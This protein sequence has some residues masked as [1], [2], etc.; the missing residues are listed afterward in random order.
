MQEITNDLFD[1]ANRLRQIDTSYRTFFNHEKSRYEVHSSHGL[2]FIV[3]YDILDERTLE[4]AR[5]TRKEN[6]C[7]IENEI[8]FH[9]REIEQSAYIKLQHELRRLDDMM[10]FANQMGGNITFHKTKEWI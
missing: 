6:L 2:E 1:I 5:R 9:N 4:H 7:D 10:N 3:P 8:E